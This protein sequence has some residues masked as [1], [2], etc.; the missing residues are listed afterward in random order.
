V[1]YTEEEEGDAEFDKSDRPVPD[2][3]ADE[4]EFEG[5][6][7]VCKRDEEGAPAETVDYGG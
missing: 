6:P 3:L 4:D 2:D 7:A 1:L 5:G